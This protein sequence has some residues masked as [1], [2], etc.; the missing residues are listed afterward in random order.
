MVEEERRPAEKRLVFVC[1]CGRTEQSRRGNPQM[2]WMSLSGGVETLIELYRCRQ[3]D[4]D[5]KISA[6]EV[7]VKTQ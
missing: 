7:N 1:V 3:H 4:N 5:K 6:E 2:A